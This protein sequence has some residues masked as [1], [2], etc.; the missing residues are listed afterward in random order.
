[1]T[2][3]R[4]FLQL[5][6]ALAVLVV[7][8]GVAVLLADAFTVSPSRPHATP[9]TTQ[10]DRSGSPIEVHF[11][12]GAYVDPPIYTEPERISAFEDFE[13]QLGHRLGVYHTYHPW[14]QPFPSEADRYFADRGTTVL[15]SWAGTDTR[16]INSGVYD[17]LIRQRAADV[18]AL[19]DH[20]ILQ[21]RWEMN[22]R[23]LATEIHSPG[24]YAE[25]WR[26]IHR[27]FDE[28]GATEV[29]WAWCPLSD[30]IADL[31]FSAY[32]PGDEWVDFIGA[33]GYARTPDQSLA[34]VFEPF[35]AWAADRKRPIL[36]GEF[37]RPV[38]MGTHASLVQ[39]LRDGLRTLA[40]RRQVAVVVYFESGRGTSG[41]YDLADIPEAMAELRKW[42]PS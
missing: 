38:D 30:Q 22:R 28:M 19:G 7:V 1:V 20:V 14:T 41:E 16:A 12:F 34:D 24:E 10:H 3:S 5:A 23:N 33:N 6:V 36:I 37:G 18:R 8:G 4:G 9:G 13:S 17:D 26:H 32:Y 15:I 2:R 27:I 39:W 11:N 31:D 42:A 25:A 40:A 35:F 21:W 29:R